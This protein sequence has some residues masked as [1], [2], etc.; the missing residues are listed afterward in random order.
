MWLSDPDTTAHA[1]GMG[2]PTTL[3]A[4]RRVDREVANIQNGLRTAGLLDRY[5]IWV[6]SDHGFATYTGAADV[7]ARLKP[8]AG[9]VNGETAIYVRDGAVRPK[10]DT[11]GGGVAAGSV[12]G[13]SVTPGGVRLQADRRQVVAQIVSALQKTPGIGAIFTRGAKTGALLGS[14]EG[15]LSFD[16]ARWS[17]ARSG[18]ILYSPDWTDGKNTHGIAGTS[19]S[20]GVAGHGSSSP[21]EIH[22]TLIAAGPDIRQAATV[23]IPTGNVDFA[24]TFLHMLGLAVPPT[25]QGRPM[26]EALRT[27]TGSRATPTVRQIQQTASTADGSYSQ[28]AYFSIV[29]VDKTEY[30]Y[31]DYTRVVRK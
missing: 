4:L 8:F 26:L 9:I 15:T 3:E 27:T 25:M 14:V 2:H 16:A 18:D 1:L 20:N 5:N 17:H 13:S 21:F 24:P 22:N 31:L 10:P 19:A 11:T 6:T 12:T 7:R 29:R 23:S 28:T 30:R